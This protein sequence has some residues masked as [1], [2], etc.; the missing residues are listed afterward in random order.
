VDVF[1]LGAILYECLTGRPPFHGASRDEALRQARQGEVVAPRRLN[2]RVP[3]ALERAC[4]R[5]LAANSA[6]RHPTAA[7]LAGDLRRYLRRRWL[8]AKLAAGLALLGALAA[9]VAVAWPRQP[10][11]LSPSHAARQA[12]GEGGQDVALQPLQIKELA[13]LATTGSRKAWVNVLE[14]PADGLPVRN[15]EMIH[16]AVTL[17]LPGHVYIVYLDGEGDAIPLYPWNDVARPG[18]NPELRVLSLATPPPA[19]P[20]RLKVES[21]PY[22]HGWE[23]KGKSSLDTVLVLVRGTPLPRSVKLDRLIR[24]LKPAPLDNKHELVVRAYDGDRPVHA[25]FRDV[26]RGLKE[27]AQDVDDELLR[28]ITP[29]FAHFEMVRAVRFAHEG[30]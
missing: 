27:K 8:P 1:G 20:A 11:D 14:R 22:P 18:G 16:V 29:L 23:E 4:L 10:P 17:N 13:V 15:G 6:R 3:A 28:L 19:R 5:A 25:L 30:D 9:V 12:V 21:P 7:A 2:R 24:R 26:E